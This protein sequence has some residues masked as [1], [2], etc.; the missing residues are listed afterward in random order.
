[1]TRMAFLRIIRPQHPE[2][3]HAS[4][5]RQRDATDIAASCGYNHSG[6]FSAASEPG[7]RL[8]AARSLASQTRS[9]TAKSAHFADET[10]RSDKTRRQEPRRPGA[11]DP[12]FDRC[13]A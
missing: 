11:A 13:D 2:G 3:F 10:I 8:V 5:R 9:M 6:E 1:M 12:G 4:R 7:P